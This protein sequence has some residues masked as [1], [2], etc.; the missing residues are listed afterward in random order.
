MNWVEYFEQV[1]KVR[2]GGPEM[3]LGIGDTVVENARS[4]DEWT[5]K[6]SALREIFTLM[7]GKPPEKYSCP[8]DPRIED[9]IDQGTYM[10]RIVSYNV[11]PA[12]RI[13]A[14]VLIPHNKPFP[15]PA[16][17][18]I[19]PTTPFGKEQVVGNDPSPQGRDQS[20]GLHLVERGYI[21]FSYDLLSANER[22]YPGLKPF[23][24]DPFY[25]DFP[26]WSVRGKDMWDISRAIDVLETI[27]QVDI[28]R[29]GS[30][31]HSQGGGITIDAMA[32]DPRIKAGVNNCGDWP[33]RL[34]KNPF[35]RARTGWW[36]GMPNLRPFCWSGKDY[37]IDLHEK[38][39]L[40]APRPLLNL[41]ALNDWGFGLDEEP[42]TRPCL[43]AM[44]A[45]V[46]KVYELYD[47]PQ[48]FES[49]LHGDGHCFAEHHR[50]IA[51]AFL[52]HHLQPN[53]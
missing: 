34:Y 41:T 10:K 21:T 50:R 8:L 25:R 3:T 48:N 18:T 4:V 46:K 31:G 6:A 36:I 52:D 16:V 42:V 20:Y 24:T 27:P 29:I 44:A 5:V 33:S 43:E 51:Y 30:I 15:R 22:I 49:V 17:L 26:N 35:V 7:L 28:A 11:G 45:S 1:L 40:A 19:H 2:R 9:E 13:R 53:I 38:M 12:E 39:A 37:P 23:S 14:Y 32:L 47:C